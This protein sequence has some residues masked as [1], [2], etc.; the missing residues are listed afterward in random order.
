MLRTWAECA[1]SGKV[2]FRRIAFVL[3]KPISWVFGIHLL[4]V[5]VTGGLCENRGGCYQQRLRVALYHIYGVRKGGDGKA[6]DERV[7][8][9]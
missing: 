3:C 1:Q 7:Y 4:A 9:W 5:G 8:S 2:R 6:I